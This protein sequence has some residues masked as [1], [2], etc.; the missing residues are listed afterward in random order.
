MMSPEWMVGQNPQVIMKDYMP[1]AGMMP[2]GKKVTG[3]TSKPDTSGM[4]KARDEMMKRPGFENIDAVKNG[5]VYVTPFCEFMISPR[6]PVALGYMA[7]WFY[8]D[9]FEDL[10]P[11][12]FH[13][14]WLK[15]W[16]GL[17]YQGVFV[18]PEE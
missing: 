1:I 3:Y 13:A 11:Q 18:Y 9:R 2:A 12:A 17:E 7:K 10:D 4:K 16:Q 8:P 15:K 5:R 6:W 14:E